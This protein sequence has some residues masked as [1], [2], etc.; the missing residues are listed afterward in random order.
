MQKPEE[1]KENDTGINLPNKDEIGDTQKPE[2]DKENDTGINLPNKDE[3]GDTQKPEEKPSDTNTPQKPQEKPEN[4]HKPQQ[5]S[6]N[7]KSELVFEN[8][9]LVSY[10]NGVR[11][12]HLNSFLIYGGIKYLVLNGQVASDKNG[13]ARDPQNP[14]HWYLCTN[15]GVQNYTGTAEYNG[16]VFCVEEGKVDTQKSG[17]VT[18]NGDVFYVCE[19]RIM[20]EVNGL[21]LDPVTQEWSFV[22]S[23]KVDAQTEGYVLYDTGMFYVR[24]G[25]IM[26]EINGFLQ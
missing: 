8:G 23:G 6:N 25:K 20:T 4:T 3:I 21:A 2:E 15:G 10:T 17:Y 11:D 5:P 9:I 26:T 24:G 13:L 18:N 22:S 12:K 1:D 7:N 14:R 16:A 19:G